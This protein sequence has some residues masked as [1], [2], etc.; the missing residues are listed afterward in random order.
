MF[1]ESGLRKIGIGPLWE[2][3]LFVKIHRLAPEAEGF[4]A[5][6]R[7][8]AY[9]V[10]RTGSTTT[11]KEEV[12]MTDKSPNENATDKPGQ[13]DQSSKIKKKMWLRGESQQITIEEYRGLRKSLV[14]PKVTYILLISYILFS[15]GLITWLIF[16]GEET[17]TKPDGTIITN[18]IEASKET[19]L[20]IFS[21][22]STLVTSIVS[23][24]FGSRGHG[25]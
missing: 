13:T 18:N 15:L 16:V 2:F 21:S 20:I 8:L 17:I 14:R 11:A 19:I 9:T 4:L 23:Y 22:L 25:K 7:G 24:W 12:I 1:D 3:D 10:R 6:V 5:F